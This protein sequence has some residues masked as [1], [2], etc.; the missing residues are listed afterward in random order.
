VR[1]TE[2]TWFAG[3]SDISTLLMPMMLRTGIATVHT[4]NL[5]NAPYRARAAL[6]LA[7]RRRP[8]D[9]VLDAL[10]R[11]GVPVIADVGCGHVPP[12][13]PIV[14][15]AL[16]HPQFSADTASLTQSRS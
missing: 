5:M 9:T 13:L 15:G 7:R 14:N 3:F 10:G 11:L 4:S 1:A 8:A 12:Y 16:G 6:D 2:P